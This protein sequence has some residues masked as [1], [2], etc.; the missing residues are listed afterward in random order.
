MAAWR[1]EISLLVLKN[2][3][4]E[5]KFR[6]SARPCNILY[7]FCNCLLMKF[8]HYILTCVNVVVRSQCHRLRNF[9]IFEASMFLHLA[10]NYRQFI[11]HFASGN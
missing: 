7:V 9:M 8:V 11:W 1:Y 6:I 2:A 10:V 4:L 5:E 3:T